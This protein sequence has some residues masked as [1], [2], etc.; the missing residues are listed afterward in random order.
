MNEHSK[1]LLDVVGGMA[2]LTA[3][4]GLLSQVMTIIATTLTAIWGAIRLY[5]WAKAKRA[6]QRHATKQPPVE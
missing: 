4:L 6:S 5:E 2:V 1:N 3:W